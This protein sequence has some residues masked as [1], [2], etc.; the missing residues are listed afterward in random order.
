MSSVSEIL[1]PT[2]IP[3]A[4]RNRITE[5]CASP[6]SMD[7]TNRSLLERLATYPA[8]KT[9]V[10][11]KLPPEPKDFEGKLIEWAFLAYTIFP[12]LRQPYPKTKAKWREWAKRLEK[13]AP[14]TDPAY[15]SQLSHQLSEEIFKAKLEMES[16]WPSLWEG[17]KCISPDQVLLVLDQLR[18][19]FGRMSEEY[20]ALLATLPKVKRWNAKARQ[21]F[22]TEVLSSRMKETYLLP[23]DSIVAA[24][25]EVAFDLRQ[26]LAAETVRGRRR[27]SGLENSE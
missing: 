3:Q 17:D 15:L 5:L 27:I 4:A 1:F 24:L 2:W 12:A 14:L 23:F 8:M 22:F 6:L 21:K 13:H 20:R 19:F 16:Y 26:G 18:L 10:W 11:E 7:G 25:T 9:D